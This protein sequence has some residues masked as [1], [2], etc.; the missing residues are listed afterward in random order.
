MVGES[1]HHMVAGVRTVTIF[2][3]GATAQ[4]LLRLFAF[5]NGPW[6]ISVFVLKSFV[7]AESAPE[8]VLAAVSRRPKRKMATA[9][10]GYFA[11]WDGRNYWWSRGGSNSWP[12]H[13]ERGALPTELLPHA[14]ENTVSSF[15]FQVLNNP[16]DSEKTL[17]KGFSYNNFTAESSAS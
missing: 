7:G 13:C 6:R 5:K 3:K 12:P 11:K 10:S 9:G 17:A 15:E 2:R 16:P 8:G 1:F 4:K 14:H